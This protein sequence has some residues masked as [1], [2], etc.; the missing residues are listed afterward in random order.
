MG[1]L[2]LP[3]NIPIP[4][5]FPAILSQVAEASLVDGRDLGDCFKEGSNVP[6]A[7]RSS[8][9]DRA[10][11]GTLRDALQVSKKVSLFILLRK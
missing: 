9:K 4:A 7:A 2:A 11:R 5:R 3:A 10:A 8:S 6:L 1:D